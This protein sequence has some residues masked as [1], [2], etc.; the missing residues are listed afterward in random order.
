VELSDTRGEAQREE[1]DDSLGEARLEHQC[2]D[3]STVHHQASHADMTTVV[4]TAVRQQEDLRDSE[5]ASE[6]LSV[7]QQV[8]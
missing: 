4:Q 7:L 8:L 5:P 1:L 3:T 6:Q 2:C